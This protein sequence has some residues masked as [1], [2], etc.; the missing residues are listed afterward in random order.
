M[1]NAPTTTDA[2]AILK[3]KEILVIPDVLANA[4][5]VTVS[6][7]E[8]EQNRKNEHWSKED[9]L[10]KLKEKMESATDEVL[11][12]QKTQKITLRDAAYMVA[13]KRFQE[14]KT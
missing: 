14:K 6:Y 11:A 10:V 3:Q 13:L 2:D 4:G 9:V 8:W 12:L 1:A 7:F 5:G